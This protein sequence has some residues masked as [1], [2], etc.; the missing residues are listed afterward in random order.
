MESWFPTNLGEGFRIRGDYVDWETDPL[1]LFGIAAAFLTVRV[2]LI[3]LFFR[4]FGLRMI[5]IKGA[6]VEKSDV[7]ELSKFEKYCWHGVGM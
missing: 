2:V 3:R 5:G 7:I 4:P 6:P 1:Y